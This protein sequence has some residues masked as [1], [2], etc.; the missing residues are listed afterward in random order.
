MVDEGSIGAF[1]VLDGF[2]ARIEASDEPQVM[3]LRI[4]EVSAPGRVPEAAVHFQARFEAGEEF[5]A[6]R[7]WMA[8]P[9]V[10]LAAVR[11]DEERG[12]L[13]L[14]LLRSRLPEV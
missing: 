7:I 8:E 5:A 11:W 14:K 4:D 2:F 10:K 9:M 3:F 13:R 6:D 12:V 1:V